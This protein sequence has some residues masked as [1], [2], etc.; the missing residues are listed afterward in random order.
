MAPLTA[1][2]VTAVDRVLKCV[3]EAGHPATVDYVSPR[4]WAV[5]LRWATPMPAVFG[6]RAHRLAAAP[7]GCRLFATGLVLPG[8]GDWWEA[9]LLDPKALA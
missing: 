3:A 8:P 6:Q 4:G 9:T 5:V 2:L 1:P 7:Q